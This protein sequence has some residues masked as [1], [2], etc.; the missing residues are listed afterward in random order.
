MPSDTYTL[1][2]YGDELVAFMGRFTKAAHRG[3]HRAAQAGRTH[4]VK[5]IAEV[6]PFAPIDRGTMRRSYM[7]TRIVSGYRLENVAPHAARQEYGTAPH[8]PVKSDLRAWARRKEGNSSESAKLFARAF[9][10]IKKRGIKPKRFHTVASQKFG[11][12]L[13]DAMT[14]ELRRVK[15]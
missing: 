6:K 10:A 12:F 7:I 9:R 13:V 14:T 5:V 1:D 15:R 11:H 2:T 8:T 3:M 4:V